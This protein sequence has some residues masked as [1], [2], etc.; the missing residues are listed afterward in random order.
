MYV[1]NGWL[2]LWQDT[3]GDGEFDA[4][5][6]AVGEIR[7]MFDSVAPFT[8]NW[9]LEPVNGTYYLRITVDANR[10]RDEAADVER[11]IRK[12]CV[13]LPG[14]W[15]VFYERDDEAVEPPG[16]N[17]FRVWAVARGEISYREDPFLSPCNP[18]IED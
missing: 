8:V 11:I 14:S 12:A 7:A 15:G 13:L 9:S 4:L 2:T 5:V 1:L 6:E 10:R 18:I 3:T 16:S 17:A